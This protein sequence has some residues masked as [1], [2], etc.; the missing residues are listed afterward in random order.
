MKE[1]YRVL[2]AR[3]R[4]LLSLQRFDLCAHLQNSLSTHRTEEVHDARE[5][6]QQD[7]TSRTQPE[8]LGHETLVQGRESLFPH[9]RTESGPCPVVLGH[10][11]RNFLRILD[12]ALDDIHRSIQ[13][14]T[15]SSTNST[16][17]QIIGHLTL[18]ILSRRHQCAHLENAAKVPSVPEDVAPHC[19]LETLI[20]SQGTF[21]AHRLGEA[22]NHAGVFVCLSL[23]LETDL[24]KLKG[25]DDEGFG[26]TG[27]GAREDGEGL[28][29]FGRAGEVAVEFAP[30][31]VGGELG[32]PVEG[33]DDSFEERV[34]PYATQRGGG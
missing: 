33:K 9:D 32:S 34:G 27:G 17:N 10:L 31:I 8:H 29:H 20:E 24:D 19:A 16:R 4:I 2:N 22:V 6:D 25:D 18:L 14:S 26:G 3:P 23:I 15:D 30:F 1:G 28:G 13:N 5:N 21:L 7:T 12:A 11:S